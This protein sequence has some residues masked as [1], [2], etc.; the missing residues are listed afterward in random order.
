MKMLR[1][2]KCDIS[3]KKFNFLI[4]KPSE[5]W[6]ST[7]KKLQENYAWNFSFSSNKSRN[8]I[9]KK[10]SKNFVPCK[11]NLP[12]LFYHLFLKSNN[13]FGTAVLIHSFLGSCLVLFE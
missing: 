9:I 1:H 3:L 11:L 2:K 6:F 4:S 8:S 10:M 13:C 12:Y 5:A 7:L